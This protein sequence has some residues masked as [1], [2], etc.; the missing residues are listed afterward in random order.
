VKVSVPSSGVSES[1]SPD[2]PMPEA[3]VAAPPAPS[4]PQPARWPAWFGGADFASAVLVCVAAFAVG[5]FTAKNSD[6]YVHLAAGRLIAEGQYRFGADPFSY[7]GESRAWVNPAWLWQRI[8]Y[9]LYVSDP[10]G[11]WLVAAKAVGF[12]VGTI[13]L[14]LIRRNGQPLWPWAVFAGLAVVAGGP[15]TTLRPWA[16][17]APFV[18]ITLFLLYRL[19]WKPGSWRNPI[20]LAATCGLWANLDGGFVLG[21]LTILLVLLGEWLQATVMKGGSS[22]PGAFGPPPPVAGLAKA[23]GLAI[24]ACMANPNHVHVWQLPPEFAWG[25]PAAGMVKDA[26]LAPAVLE[27]FDKLFWGQPL[28][29]ENVNGL[30]YLILFLASALAMAL[31][32]GRVRVAHL[33]VWLLFAY[34]S[35]HQWMFILPFS[36]VAAAIAAAYANLW[37][38]AIELKTTAHP[39]T[40]FYLLGSGI[41]RLVTTALA[42]VMVPLAWPG[43]LHPSSGNP[44]NMRRVAWAVEPDE[45]LAAMATTMNAWRAKG[46]L[47]ADMRTLTPNLDFANYLAWYAPA[48][49]VFFNSR[50]GFHTPEWPDV[51][52]IR[53]ELYVNPVPL[54]DGGIEVTATQKVMAKAGA[55]ALAAVGVTYRPAG[56]TLVTLETTP[57]WA[58]WAI[59][60]RGAVVGPES[61]TK[62][63]FNP[64]RELLAPDVAPLPDVNVLTP[65]T[66]RETWLDDFLTKPKA[67]PFAND[68]ANALRDYAQFLGR[69]LQ[70]DHARQSFHLAAVTGGLGAIRNRGVADEEFA[71]PLLAVRAA[72]KAL[73]E[74]PDAPDTYFGLSQL[75]SNPLLP[76]IFAEDANRGRP[77]ERQLQFTAALQRFLARVPKPEACD[78]RQAKLAHAC[79]EQLAQTYLQT[80]QLDLARDTFGPMKKYFQVGPGAEYQ[81]LMR[82]AGEN[83]EKVKAIKAEFDGRNKQI[84]DLETNVEK[85]VAD[86]ADALRR[87]QLKG[88]QKFFATLQSGLP[89]AAL[90]SFEDLDPANLEAEYGRD[91]IPVAVAVVDLLARAGRV[92]AA[93]QQLNRLTAY[94]EELGKDAKADPNFVAQVRAQVVEREY[95]VRVLE[96]NYRSA[97][98]ALE[99]AN[100]SRFP[101]LP[102]AVRAAAKPQSLDAA[103]GLA[104][105]LP[106]LIAHQPLVVNVNALYAA[107]S[108]FAYSRALLAVLDGRPAEAKA[109]F[110]QSLAPQGVTGLPLPWAGLASR[111]LGMIEKAGANP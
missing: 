25:L 69:K 46:W 27:P 15:Y 7:S 1:S 13:L 99:R 93:G 74:N 84:D 12:A 44:A 86:A 70:F 55:A 110:T 45:G 111:F 43:Y 56:D 68:D 33:L 79:L 61:Y 51:L 62:L 75:Y 64:V 10:T 63:A 73:A 109:R 53:Q 77:G 98:E 14:I 18:A 2:L 96:G 82:Q 83:Q 37:S 36:V 5:S 20:L 104:G 103:F 105:P 48:E 38:S 32:F 60:G 101:P 54:Q 106:V 35:L 78:I 41:G 29:G 67:V 3:P 66:P 34:L 8:A 49:K 19:D 89:G 17:N 28:R 40:R 76:E 50:F 59:N 31:S 42:V 81:L 57:G 65:P 71:V 6:L 92:E 11:V 16:V 108:E 30:S 91:A 88:A 94:A 95:R 24:V 100:V 85:R 23:L 52:T 22:V 26:E 97:A 87:A 9:Q 47:P 107:E 90:K 21:P 80:G 39:A 72:R 58:V 4:G 102:T